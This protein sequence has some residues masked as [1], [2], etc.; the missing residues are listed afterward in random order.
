MHNPIVMLLVQWQAL[1]Q[2]ENT[3]IMSF[4]IQK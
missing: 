4:Y 2:C 1:G 3:D